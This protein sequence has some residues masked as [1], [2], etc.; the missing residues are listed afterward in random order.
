MISESELENLKRKIGLSVRYTKLD[1][2]DINFLQR[3]SDNLKTFGIRAFVS[4]SDLHELERI[5]TVALSK[6]D[7]R[8]SDAFGP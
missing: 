8:K 2:R 5:F 4:P 7:N 1:Q 6:A 3:Q